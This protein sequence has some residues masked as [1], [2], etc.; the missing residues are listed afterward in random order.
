MYYFD[1]DEDEAIPQALGSSKLYNV[2]N[3]NIEKP[4]QSGMEYL[5]R[6]RLLIIQILYI[7]VYLMATTS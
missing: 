1:D 5:A 4:P 7:I 3:M 6:V 2:E